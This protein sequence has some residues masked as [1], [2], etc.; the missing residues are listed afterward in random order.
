MD[1]CFKQRKQEDTNFGKWI[2][3]VQLSVLLFNLCWSL[4]RN[5][6]GFLVSSTKYVKKMDARMKQLNVIAQKL[7]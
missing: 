3:L 1:L 5:T 7:R 4:L 6:L 2:L